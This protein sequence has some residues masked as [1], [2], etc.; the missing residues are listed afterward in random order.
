MDKEELV[1]S[2]NTLLADVFALYVR[3]HGFH[4]NVEGED[5]SQYHELFQTIYEDV[6]GSIDPI[7]ENIRK[8]DGKAPASLN[9][10]SDLTDLSEN[11]TDATAPG[12]LAQA[13]L[14]MNNKVLESLNVAFKAATDEDEQGIANF[15]SERIDMHQKWRWQLSASLSKEASSEG[16]NMANENKKTSSVL[17]ET[18][19]ASIP[20]VEY[21]SEDDPICDDCEHP[22]ALH[23]HDDGSCTVG[24]AYYDGRGSEPHPDA[25]QCPDFKNSEY[26]NWYS[27]T[28]SVKTALEN[29]FDGYGR[30]FSED[31]L[32][33]NVDPAYYGDNPAS[34]TK[35]Y[36]GPNSYSINTTAP[37]MPP[38]SGMEDPGQNVGPYS[39]PGYEE[40]AAELGFVQASSSN[41]VVC[42]QCGSGNLTTVKGGMMC[43]DCMSVMNLEKVS[44]DESA[45]VKLKPFEIDIQNGVKPFIKD[46]NEQREN[47]G[48]GFKSMSDAERRD[49]IDRGV[50]SYFTRTNPDE[51]TFDE[52]DKGHKRATEGCCGTP[53]YFGLPERC[54]EEGCDWGD[55]EARPENIAGPRA[56]HENS[57][58]YDYHKKL[59]GMTDEEFFRFVSSAP[60][61]Y[62]S[63]N[64]ETEWFDGTSSSIYQRI[65]SAR[66]IQKSAD[67]ATASLIEEQIKVLEK[68]A[69]EFE[70]SSLA[71][72]MTSVPGGTVAME[73][74]DL[75]DGGLVD[76]S[77]FISTEAHKYITEVNTYDW[78]KFAEDAPRMWV[79]AKAKNNPGLLSHE[80]AAREAAIDYVKSKTMVLMDP[81]VRADIIDNFVSDVEVQ[82]RSYL[83]AT[84]KKAEAEAERREAY[85]RQQRARVAAELSEL[86]YAD[87]DTLFP[88]QTVV[89]TND[90][91][92]FGEDDGSAMYA[93]ARKVVEAHA[94]RN[95]ES[96]CTEGARDW[97]YSNEAGMY[98]HADTT[99]IA[100]KQYVDEETSL[101]KDPATKTEI[102]RAF[103]AS[104]DFLREEWLQ[105]QASLTEPE[106]DID[107]L[108]QYYDDET[109][110]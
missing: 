71:E 80:H 88:G 39:P 10:L 27:K 24:A 3:A 37:Y 105:K 12:S 25:C 64:N 49:A 93:E 50:A 65:A 54:Y 7:A 96:F 95:W 48:K 5:F 99:R 82:R 18:P 57:K 74:D 2:L 34:D 36:A 63:W 40:E 32:N 35:P 103:L 77:S 109:L 28:S 66:Q 56:W 1:Q 90:P 59:K 108:S 101:V 55:A 107:V 11:G 17:N 26:D 20:L 69:G 60:K 53:E 47:Y 87:D 92:D 72:Y 42:N 21:L 16:L 94:N 44:A 30:P 9:Q 104:V 62:E 106:E 45:E 14:D 78:E 58:H 15:L 41:E 100:A 86:E 73:Y 75:M 6:Y 91:F 97:F 85:E 61:T 31:P 22:W 70:D 68:V 79:S 51:K 43:K 23:G 84:E 38:N 29:P 8:L 76:V 102:R 13:L 19:D 46:Y 89:G 81:S 83:A 52:C 98:R 4:W 110:W 67:K 33:P